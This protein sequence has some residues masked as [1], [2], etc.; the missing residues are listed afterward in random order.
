MVGKYGLGKIIENAVTVV[1]AI[2][3]SVLSRRPLLDRVR[4]LAVRTRH[5]LWPSLLTEILQTILL[6][7][8][9][10]L[11]HAL[12]ADHLGVSCELHLQSIHCYR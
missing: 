3:L 11:V 4:T 6:V 10:N 9:K 7:R 5:L 12:S 2:A 8:Q 1:T